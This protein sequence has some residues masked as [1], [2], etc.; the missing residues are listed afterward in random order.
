MTKPPVPLMVPPITRSPRCFA[1][2]IDSPVTIDS[3]T[4]L[5]PSTTTPSTGTPRPAG[6]GA[7]RRW[8]RSSGISSSSPP[9]VDPARRLGREIEQRADGAAGLLARAQFEHLAEQHQDLITAA[10]SK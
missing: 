4:A 8:T 7:G 6:R 2:G 3:S 10:A 9:A 1:T 5:L